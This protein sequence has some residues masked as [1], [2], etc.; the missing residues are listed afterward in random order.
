MASAH[1]TAP[2]TAA[3]RGRPRDPARDTRILEAAVSLIGEVGYDRTTLDAIA[4]RAG[5]S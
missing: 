3:H 5:V 2:P 1:G 4:E